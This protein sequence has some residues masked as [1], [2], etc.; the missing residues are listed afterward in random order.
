MGSYPILSRDHDFMGKMD[1]RRYLA[2]SFT[3]AIP[4]HEPDTGCRNH[5]VSSNQGILPGILFTHVFMVGSD[6]QY[7]I[8]A[9]DMEKKIEG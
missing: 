7:F 9:S 2:V 4:G 6:Y 8:L 5:I 3:M 1:S